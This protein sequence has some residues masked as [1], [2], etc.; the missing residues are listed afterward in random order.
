MA[1]VTCSDEQK[2]GVKDVDTMPTAQQLKVRS[3]YRLA[4]P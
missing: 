3:A 2:T 1:D 4:N